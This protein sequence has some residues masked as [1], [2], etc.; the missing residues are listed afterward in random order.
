MTEEIRILKLNRTSSEVAV[1]ISSLEAPV[2][3]S[4]DSVHKHRLKEGIVITPPQLERLQFESELY[5]CD[6]EA[7]RLLALREHSIGEM[8]IKLTRKQFT[9]STIRRT[10]KK[11]KDQGMLDDTRF[12][13]TTARN[14]VERR[15]SGRSYVIAVLRS[16]MIER[17]LAEQ[18]AETV[19]SDMEELELA[20]KALQSRWSEFSQFDLEVARR[21]SYN[22]LSRRGFNY[23]A[24]K[25]AFEQLKM[26]LIEVNEDQDG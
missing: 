12:A 11:Y 7:A 14:L 20:V 22:Y 3:L 2:V 23:E 17:S 25:T 18:T 10:V 15:P 8:R 5:L 16:K 26:Q 13:L 6:R 4:E 24:A 19:L 9:S 21:K 1:T